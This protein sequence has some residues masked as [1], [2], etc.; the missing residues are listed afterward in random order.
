MFFIRKLLWKS[1]NINYGF[2][3]KNIFTQNSYLTPTQN[4]D[5]RNHIININVI[6]K[7]IDFLLHSVYKQKKV[8]LIISIPTTC[9]VMKNKHET[10]QVLSPSADNKI[11]VG[12]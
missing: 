12:S 11:G 7:S 10:K 5:H 2:P 4:V 9:T 6:V 8:D 1:K 3:L